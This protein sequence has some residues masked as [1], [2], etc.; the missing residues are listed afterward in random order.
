[1]DDQRQNCPDPKGQV[2]GKCSQQ[3][4][5]NNL[6][7]TF[8][9][10][11]DWVISEE[12]YSF[13]D[14][15]EYLPYEQKGCRKNAKGTHDLLF[16]DRMILKEVKRKHRILFVGWIDYKKAFDMIPLTWIMEC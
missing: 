11:T 10:N 7:A 5:D 8:L 2:K 14:D 16:I 1:M 15:N 6:P 13:L 12:I 4:P 9:E 3:L